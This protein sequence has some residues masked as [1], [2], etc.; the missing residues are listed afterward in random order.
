MERS[1]NQAVYRFLPDVWISEKDEESG[2]AV[3]ARI[4]KLELCENG[5]YL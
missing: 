5:W 1:K 4:K 3:T 2:H